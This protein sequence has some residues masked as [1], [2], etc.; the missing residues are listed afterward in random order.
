MAFSN[1]RN[2]YKDAPLGVIQEG[3]WADL[4]I[5]DGNP[6]EDIKVVVDHESH[7]KVVVKN[8]VIY[9]NTLGK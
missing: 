1:S 6:L 8:G 7:L 4:L 2:P 5:Y 3:A 9:K